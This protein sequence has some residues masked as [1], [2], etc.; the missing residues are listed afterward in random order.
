MNE[1]V[2]LECVSVN[3]ECNS[4]NDCAA[5]SFSYIQIFPHQST[6]QKP[7]HLKTKWLHNAINWIIPL[8]HPFDVSVLPPHI[9]IAFLKGQGGARL[10]KGWCLF[11]V[12]L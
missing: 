1:S 7:L 10:L 9:I 6:T 5:D 8:M 2:K 4:N 11:A 3:L 12:H